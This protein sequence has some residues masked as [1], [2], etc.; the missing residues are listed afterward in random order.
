MN[1]P[2]NEYGG[3]T[4]P[5]KFSLENDKYSNRN[6]DS[7]LNR[8]VT[9]PFS[10]LKSSRGSGRMKNQDPGVNSDDED[11]LDDDDMFG[12]KL[13]K[14]SFCLVNCSHFSYKQ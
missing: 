5:N 2:D 8:H 3:G 11:G 9:D 12:Y 4:L 13:N 1:K 7:S 14:K 6:V 10:K